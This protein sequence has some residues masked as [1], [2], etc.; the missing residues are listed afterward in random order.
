MEASFKII[1]SIYVLQNDIGRM[2]SFGPL[3]EVRGFKDLFDNLFA[4]GEMIQFFLY[5]SN[6]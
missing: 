6:E 3:N 4:P 1:S 2:D 5:F